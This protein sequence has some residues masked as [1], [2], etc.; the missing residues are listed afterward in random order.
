[1]RGLKGSE[2]LHLVDGTSE[3]VAADWKTIIDELEAYGG[4]LA[5]KPRLTA[6]NKI[7]ALDE[8]EREEK[9]AALAAVAGHTFMMSGVSR[10]GVTE[11]LRAVRRQV[12]AQ[13][14]REAPAEEEAP[15]L[16]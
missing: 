16:R 7:D 13:R 6:L 5:D 14:K 9:R 10:E 2:V 15:W 12:D 11:V 3:D 4:A 1:M 8:E